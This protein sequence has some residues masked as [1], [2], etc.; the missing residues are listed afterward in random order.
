MRSFALGAGGL[1]LLLLA[2]AA[3]AEPVVISQGV[4]P[5]FSGEG[6]GLCHVAAAS[7]NPTVD[8]GLLE[9]A[10]F[11]TNVNLYV[12]Q[13]KT[14]FAAR[15][16]RAPFDFTGNGDD[17]PSTCSDSTCDLIVTDP[18]KGSA[19]R[20]RGYFNVTAE[21]ANK[22][23][24]F[25]F[26]ADDAVALV[27]YDHEYAPHPIAVRPPQLGIAAWRLTAEVNFT[28]PGLYPIEVV[29]VQIAEH[30]ALEMS[31]FIGEFQDFERP[32]N[33][34]P[35]IRLNDAGFKLL[36]PTAFFQTLSG[37]PSFP[38]L[39]TCTQCN[40][41]FVNQVPQADCLAAYYCNEAALCAPCD[42]NRFCGSTCAPC[43]GQTPY[44]DSTSETPQCVA[45]RTDADCANGGTCDATT[46]TCSESP[47]SSSSAGG[48]AGAGGAGGNGAVPS[49][50]SCACRAVSSDSSTSGIAAMLGLA[51][52]GMG[53]RHRRRSS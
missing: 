41:E 4:A 38:D 6:T 34:V 40:R 53:L 44:C 9:P 8:F 18:A 36:E 1:S 3:H 17:F 39:S 35:I 30:A 42:T 22:P 16:L 33:E 51:F 29:H 32:V 12:D 5:P 15:V 47:T 24:H 37:N 43:G 50:G 28:T 27:I 31:Y 19:S 10:N 26:V 49:E 48:E 13:H 23:L 2:G 11:L 46:K 21:L 52:V 20:L 7:T 14:D 25:G 45:C